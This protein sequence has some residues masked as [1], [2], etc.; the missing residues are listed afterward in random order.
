MKVDKD[1]IQHLKKKLEMYN[2]CKR[3][4]KRQQEYIMEIEHKMLSLPKQSYDGVKSTN[5]TTL[6]QWIYIKDEAY[7]TLHA[8]SEYR[9]IQEIGLYM[10]CLDDREKQF[11]RDKFFNELTYAKMEKKYKFAG[12]TLNY[13][14]DR[15]IEKMIKET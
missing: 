7:K 10:K 8:M 6:E 1:A 9:M 5:H 2:S 14:I 11:I 12:Q 13:H 4:I 15:I 3:D